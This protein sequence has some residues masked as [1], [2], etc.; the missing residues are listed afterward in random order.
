MKRQ[1]RHCSNKRR[2]LQE[3]EINGLMGFLD[4]DLKDIVKH[5]LP[6]SAFTETWS[7]T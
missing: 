5:Y 4:L 6:W 1:V 3:Q 2:M 7:G